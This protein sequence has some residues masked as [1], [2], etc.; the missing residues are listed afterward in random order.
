MMVAT[1]SDWLVVFLL[2]LSVHDWPLALI[3]YDLLLS[4]L[5]LSTCRLYN[6]SPEKFIGR[7]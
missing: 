4:Y 2:C 6:Q 5:C 7:Y 1:S 3:F